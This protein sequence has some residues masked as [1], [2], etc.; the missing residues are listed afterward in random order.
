[1]SAHSATG[2]AVHRRP[3]LLKRLVASDHLAGWAF[4]APAVILI[5]VFAIIPI[6]WALLLSLQSTNLIAPAHYIGLA[7]YRALTKDPAFRSAI[8]QAVQSVLLAKA[9]PKHALNQA[10]QQVNGILAAP[11]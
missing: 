11:G 10:A 7:N 1:M 2:I 4:V 3:S 5:A 6:G 9:S 8:G